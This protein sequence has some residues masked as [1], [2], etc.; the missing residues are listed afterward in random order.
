[1][2]RADIARVVDGDRR[3]LPREEHLPQLHARGGRA[4]SDRNVFGKRSHQTAAG[5]AGRGL[6]SD[7]GHHARHRSSR[8]IEV[9]PKTRFTKLI[10][11]TYKL[12]VYYSISAFLCNS[13]NDLAILYNDISVLESHHAALTF[14]LTTKDDRLNIFKGT[15]TNW[16]VSKKRG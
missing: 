9:R 15:Y 1:M 7:R 3:P 13:Q 12:I 10:V 4:A 2:R 11:K 5:P 6:L 8:Q 16:P 14:K